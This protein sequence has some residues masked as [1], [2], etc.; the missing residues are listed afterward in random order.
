MIKMKEEAKK[1]FKNMWEQYLDG[2]SI[3]TNTCAMFMWLI[4]IIMPTTLG[5]IG[6]YLGSI[7]TTKTTRD[8][9]VGFSIILLGIGLFNL[10]LAIICIIKNN[11]EVVNKDENRNMKKLQSECGYWKSQLE[12]LDRQDKEKK[13]SECQV[14]TNQINS[15][16]KVDTDKLTLITLCIVTF[17]LYGIV[18]LI[19]KCK[20]KNNE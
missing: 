5:G 3:H 2:F 4:G 1:D 7:C 14:S 8:I 17:G 6:I 13:L 15:N 20:N 19:K 9:C 12:E 18:Y 16:D 11:F 10:T